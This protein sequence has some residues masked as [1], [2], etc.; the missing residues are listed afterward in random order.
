MAKIYELVRAYPNDNAL[1]YK[2][3]KGATK[4]ALG[5][6]D[7]PIFLNGEAC[8]LRDLRPGD[9]I[10]LSAK[11]GKIL[12]VRATRAKGAAPAKK[13]QPKKSPPAKKALPAAA[14]AAAEPSA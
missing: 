8:T 1:E 12:K 14:E 11:V 3:D 13:A 5:E 2:S 6:D 4:M 7:V 9:K 10:E